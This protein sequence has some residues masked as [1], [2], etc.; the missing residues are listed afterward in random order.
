[1][2]TRNQMEY[3][4]EKTLEDTVNTKGTKLWVMMN[5][6][7]KSTKHRAQFIST[8]GGF[9]IKDGRYWK[10]TNPI[11]EKNGY[12]LKR[13]DTEEKTFF[14]NMSEFAESQ[15]MTAVKICEL[16]NGKRK[17]YK[18]WTAVETREVKD[19]V[20][21]Y[22][23]LEEPKAKTV[24]TTKMYMLVDTTTNTVMNIPNLSQFAKQNNLDYSALKKLVN[25]R[26]KTYKNLKV[27]NPLE[28]YKDS[29]EPK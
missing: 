27:Y 6:N 13:V 19:S 16:L 29:Q 24:M 12:W 15:G 28:K 25:G 22:E 26:A 4:K 21:S 3:H 2:N 8:H 10:W 9:F 1:M 18:G 11:A 7:S 14:R 20:G 17:T 5:D 23:K